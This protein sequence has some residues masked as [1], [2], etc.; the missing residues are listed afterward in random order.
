M[1]KARPFYSRR[2]VGHFF[3]DNGAQ[4]QAVD[5]PVE[6]AE[7]SLPSQGLV[8]ALKVEWLR[9]AKKHKVTQEDLGMYARDHEFSSNASCLPGSFMVSR[10]ADQ[11]SGKIAI[12]PSLGHWSLE[13][14]HIYRFCHQLLSCHSA[15]SGVLSLSLNKP[16]DHS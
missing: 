10:S 7:M 14:Y 6:D 15:K 12:S 5:L 16:H 9:A 3:R 8:R 13:K 4:K 1:I 11:R 2:I